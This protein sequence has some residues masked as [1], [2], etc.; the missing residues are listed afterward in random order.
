M[1]AI[2]TINP[3]KIVFVKLVFLIRNHNN[4]KPR[5]KI[6]GISSANI[7]QKKTGIMDYRIIGLLD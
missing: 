2:L 7:M 4:G 3:P 1:S 6:N 5:Q